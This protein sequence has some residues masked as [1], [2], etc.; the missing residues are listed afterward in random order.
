M[1]MKDFL[2][3]DSDF[4]LKFQAKVINITNYIQNCLSIKS[5]I[6]EL[7][8]KKTWTKKKQDVSHIKVFGSIV[9]ILIPKEKSKS[10]ISIKIKMAY[11][12]AIAK[13]LPNTSMYELQKL[14]KSYQLTI[15]I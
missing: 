4:F 8:L 2:L 1:I 13:T 14:S 10:H 12:L 7:V 11:L 15:F 9:N 3:I 6:S 5:Q